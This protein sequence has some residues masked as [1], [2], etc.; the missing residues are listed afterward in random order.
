[1]LKTSGVWGLELIVLGCH[2]V[3]TFWNLIIPSNLVW[4][5]RAHVRHRHVEFRCI[6]LSRPNCTKPTSVLKSCPKTLTF[7][8][9]LRFLLNKGS[10]THHFS[11]SNIPRQH[12]EALIST[13]PVGVVSS[14]QQVNIARNWREKRKFFGDCDSKSSLLSSRNGDEQ[15]MMT[16]AFKPL[17]PQISTYHDLTP[18]SHGKTGVGRGWYFIGSLQFQRAF[19]PCAKHPGTNCIPEQ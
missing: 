2:W 9:L 17:E 4:I 10:S 8:W 5:K 6:L 16:N 11:P 19:D 12:A 18:V 1:M 15:I 13:A 14:T 3:G 7:A